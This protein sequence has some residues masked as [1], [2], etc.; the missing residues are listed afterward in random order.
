MAIRARSGPD[1]IEDECCDE[2]SE[3]DSNDMIAKR[4]MK[5]AKHLYVVYPGFL[6]SSSMAEIVRHRLSELR[7]FV[8]Q[9]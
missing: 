8:M 6:Y 1:V 5:S 2:E 7:E 4:E 3:K 9:A